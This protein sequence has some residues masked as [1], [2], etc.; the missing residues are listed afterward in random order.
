MKNVEAIQQTRSPQFFILPS[1][2]ELESRAGIAPACAVLQT[3]A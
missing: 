2:F 3:A 1:S